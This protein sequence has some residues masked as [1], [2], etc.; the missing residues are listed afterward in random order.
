MTLDTMRFLLKALAKISIPVVVMLSI[1]L[2]AQETR[3]RCFQVHVVVRP[4]GIGDHLRIGISN[5]LKRFTIGLP[6]NVAGASRTCPL[7]G[8]VFRQARNGDGTRTGLV[9]PE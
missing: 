9:D 6:K 8:Q 1:R 3:S 2:E 4:G 5:A 7:Q